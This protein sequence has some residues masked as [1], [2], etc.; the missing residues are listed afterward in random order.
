[1]GACRSDGVQA[2]SG[3]AHAAVT[4]EWM[5]VSVGEAVA[6]TL[7][8]VAATA[9]GTAGAA[10][11][12]PG[13]RV[14][15][16]IQHLAAGIVFAAVALELVPPVRERSAYVAIIGF[17]VGIAAM[18]LLKRATD[19]LEAGSRGAAAGAIALPIGLL[20]ATAIDVFIDGVVLGAGFAAG[21][22]Q[23]VLLT[24]ALTLELLF[25]GLAVAGAVASLRG[26]LVT[27]V[28][29]IG[30]GLLLTVG[31]VVG[32]LSLGHASVDVLDATLAFGAVALMYLVTEELLTEAHEVQE[33]PWATALFFVGFLAYLLAAEAVG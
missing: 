28:L 21:S 23:G 32:L 7:I 1:M 6:F 9:L 22:R 27:I 29:G 13:P 19:R 5:E 11:R 33:T 10:V 30:V 14:T 20:V 25:L 17:G 26:R 24:I 12:P 18:T 15:S 8:P 31:T 16:A 2:R 4:V 3:S